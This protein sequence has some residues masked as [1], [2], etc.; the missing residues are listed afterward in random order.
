MS[1]LFVPIVCDAAAYALHSCLLYAMLQHM[2]Y[3]RAYCMRCCSICFTFLP[4]VCDAAEY[5]LHSCLLYAM[6]QHMLYIR[7]YC[8]RCYSI[9][10][11]FVPIVCDAATAYALHSCLLY[12]MLLQHMLY[13]QV[14][15]HKFTYNVTYN[16]IKFDVLIF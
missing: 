15:R 16:W 5:A 4:I 3:I 2:L 12:A 9:C 14:Q 1:C 13:I 6:L 8:M 7:A 10:F 11:T